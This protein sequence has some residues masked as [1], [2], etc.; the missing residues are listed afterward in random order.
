MRLFKLECK[1]I[2]ASKQF[3]F[4]LMIALFFSVAITTIG[5][6]DSGND[7]Q[8]REDNEIASLLGV[9]IDDTFRVEYWK[10]LTHRPEFTNFI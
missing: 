8:I 3:V 10:R 2:I 5:I 7:K 9:V 4:G 6:V 1:R